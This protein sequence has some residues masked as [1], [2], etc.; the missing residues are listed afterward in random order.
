MDEI[1]LFF[2]IHYIRSDTN[3]HRRQHNRELLL[4]FS[5]NGRSIEN[6]SR[7]LTKC[8]PAENQSSRA[9]DKW[10][11]SFQLTNSSF[12]IATKSLVQTTN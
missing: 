4:S 12:A 5:L 3:I 10:T 9:T 8:P 7:S 1:F 6:E 2:L 11:G